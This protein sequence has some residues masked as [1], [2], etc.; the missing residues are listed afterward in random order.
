MKGN[1][2]NAKPRLNSVTGHVCVYSND[3]AAGKKSGGGRN[4]RR[5]LPADTCNS[6]K[7]GRIEAIYVR[8]RRT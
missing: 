3:G 6:N 1:K 8:G 7:T 2:L 4:L 5:K